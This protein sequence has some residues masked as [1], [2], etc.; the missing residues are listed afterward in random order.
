M[1]QSSSKQQ[2]IVI[3]ISGQNLAEIAPFGTNRVAAVSLVT[4]QLYSLSRFA[5]FHTQDGQMVLESPLAHCRIILHDARSLGILHALSSPQTPNQLSDRFT[6]IPQNVLN[7]F[8][9]WLLGEKFLTAYEEE[10]TALS[11]W[12]F[13]DLL[14]HSRSRLGRHNYPYGSHLQSGK[15]EPSPAV[16]SS[17]SSS[18]ISLY[19][20]NIEALMTRDIPFT[21]VI[22]QRRSQ[23]QQGKTP[24]TVAQLGEFLY[25]T[26]RIRSLKTSESVEYEFSDRPYPSGGACY[27]LEL[28]LAINA[29]QGL[30]PGLYY[31]CPKEHLLD[32]LDGYTRDVFQL[33]CQAATETGLPQVLIILAARF[34]RVTWKYRSLG[35]SLILKHVGVLYQSMYLVSTAMGLACC[36]IGG[37]N[38][39]LF[40]QASGIDY[41]IETSVGEFILGSR[42]E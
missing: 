30:M 5:Y 6:D 28:Y 39:D 37:G 21:R 14:F 7:T 16:K 40:T 26:A 32:R 31:Y 25:R 9:S 10:E 4:N 3:S 19:R 17:V 1:N 29:C 22:E 36:A 34:P 42:V 24:I 23:R 8:L 33:S 13:H 41:L 20:P 15:A 2:P 11:L 18:P 12:E 38:S 27:E 35:Y